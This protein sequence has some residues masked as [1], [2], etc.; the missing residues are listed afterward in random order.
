MYSL[1]ERNGSSVQ[2][3]LRTFDSVEAEAAVNP[4][5]VTIEDGTVIA[6]DE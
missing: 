2:V 1:L 3:R 4:E 6:D 5:S